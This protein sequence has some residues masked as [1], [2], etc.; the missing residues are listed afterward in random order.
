MVSLDQRLSIFGGQRGRK[1]EEL[2]DW[3]DGI[4][5]SVHHE[6]RSVRAVEKT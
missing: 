1:E 6:Q 3:E 2:T 5:K 4:V